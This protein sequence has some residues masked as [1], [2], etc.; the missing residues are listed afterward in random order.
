[1]EREMHAAAH[2]HRL[3]TLDGF[4]PQLCK[5]LV[6]W[7]N[8]MSSA[9]LPTERSALKNGRT[10]ITTF[11]GYAGERRESQPCTFCTMFKP[12]TDLPEFSVVLEWHF[13]WEEAKERHDQLIKNFNRTQSEVFS[14][15]KRR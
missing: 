12:E 1:M 5:D 13:T 3:Y 4:R 2:S 9:P 14:L 6:A 7:K 8:W 11:A 10:L 15:R